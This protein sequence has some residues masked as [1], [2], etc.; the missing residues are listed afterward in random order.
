MAR[1][2]RNLELDLCPD[3]V[4]PIFQAARDTIVATVPTETSADV[5][6]DLMASWQADWDAKKAAWDAQETADQV[7]RD[8]KAQATRDEAACK[9]AE[10]DAELAAEKKEA[11]RKKPKVNNFDSN[12]GIAN[13]ISLQPSLFTLRKLERFEYVEAWYFTREGCA[14]TDAAA[15][16]NRAVNEEAFTFT[17]LNDVVSLQPAAALAGSK[18]VVKDVNL[19]WD[20]LAFAKNNILHYAAQFKWPEQH[21]ASLANFWYNLEVHPTRAMAYGD[22]IVLSYQAKARIEWHNALKHDKGFNIV[23]INDTFMQR[24]SDEVWDAVQQ[25]VVHQVSKNPSPPN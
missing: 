2:T 6:D 22:R 7:T 21:V 8:A 16:V 13:S 25:E 14:D 19:T 3:F 1:I 18:S 12:G 9:Q 11:D 10:I 24:A 17:K 5:V 15:G 20:Q 4:G 23:N